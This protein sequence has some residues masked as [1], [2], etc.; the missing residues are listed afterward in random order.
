MSR[1]YEISQLQKLF[2][3]ISRLY[4]VF[5]VLSNP[6]MP[7]SVVNR[8][9]F[10]G[11]ITI[12]SVLELVRKLLQINHSLLFLPRN[13]IIVLFK[14]WCDRLY[15]KNSFVNYRH[16]VERF[17]FMTQNAVCIRLSYCGLSFGVEFFNIRLILIRFSR[18]RYYYLT[19]SEPS[20][21]ISLVK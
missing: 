9:K 21:L 6:L 17:V 15:Y 4:F 13:Y 12:S 3:I 10:L 16:L 18:S 5:D 19:L 7:R 8:L 1:L 20:G 2:K 14:G 11:R